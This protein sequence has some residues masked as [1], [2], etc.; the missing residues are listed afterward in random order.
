MRGAQHARCDSGVLAA[1]AAGAACVLMAGGCAALSVRAGFGQHAS[2]LW[3]SALAL[4]TMM[5]V[6]WLMARLSSR[7]T[8]LAT[9][10]T[11]I[12]TMCAMSVLPA[13]LSGF[14]YGN[15]VAASMIVTGGV[16]L[17]YWQ[18]CE[19]SGRQ[20]QSACQRRQSNGV[21]T[22]PRLATPALLALLAGLSSGSLA[23]FQFS[24]YAVRA[25]HNRCGR[26]R[27]LFTRSA[28]W[29]AWRTARAATATPC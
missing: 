24:R 16:L 21:A 3:M 8:T 5:V 10:A 2:A 12:V 13:Y 9:A 19:S 15:V 26:S 18:R 25:A 4:A 28:R 23:R 1:C 22:R 7:H 14:Q 17:L 20:R 27:F 6:P 11:L 29:P